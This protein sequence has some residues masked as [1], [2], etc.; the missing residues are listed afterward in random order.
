MKRLQPAL[1]VEGFDIVSDLVA[2]AGHKVIA[3]D[4]VGN[5]DGV[6]GLRAHRILAEVSFEV[7]LG[8]GLEADTGILRCVIDADEETQPVGLAPCVPLFR[9]VTN[10]ADVLDFSI[11][12]PSG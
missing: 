4:M 11:L 12:L 10:K 1:N 8:K 5:G 2:P 9:E 6:V 3:D 7:M